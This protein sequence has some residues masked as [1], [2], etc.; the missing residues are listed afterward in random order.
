MGIIDFIRKIFK[1]D[2]QIDQLEDIDRSNWLGQ[3]FEFLIVGEIEIPIDIYDQIMTPNTLNWE[4]IY[5]N[6]WI[7]YKVGED[8]YSFSHEIPGIQFTF[9]KEVKYNKAKKIADEIIVNLRSIKQYPTLK[10]LKT[11]N[12]YRF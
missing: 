1:K 9:N 2:E 7:Y 8:E 5:K 12:V 11:G 10:V 3:D 6:D 4:K